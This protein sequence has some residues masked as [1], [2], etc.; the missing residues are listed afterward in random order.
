MQERIFDRFY[1]LEQD[2]R[3][4]VEGS[5][6]GLSL[7]RELTE[8]HGGR[9]SVRSSVSGGSEFQVALPLGFGHFQK[10]EFATHQD[11]A[12]STVKPTAMS[13]ANTT[14]TQNNTADSNKPTLLLV[15]DVADMRDYIASHFYN[16]FNV[17]TA[18]DGQQAW[19]MLQEN[20]FDIVVTDLMM[21]LMD[22]MELLANIRADQRLAST[23]VLVLSAR[24]TTEDR[25]FALAKQADDY[26]AKPFDSDELILR[27]RN[28]RQRLSSPNL[29]IGATPGEPEAPM[30]SADEQWLEKAHQAVLDNL[31]DSAFDTKQ[32]AIEMNV[33]KPTLHRHMEKAGQTT[34][35][36]FIRDIRLQKAQELIT[37][38]AYR[39]IAEVAYAVGFAS[40][41]YFSRLY[42]QRFG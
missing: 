4:G 33:S 19:L 2:D 6:I 9:V 24:S 12:F 26:L 41:G 25:N 29:Q 37:A 36:A 34:P 42:K 1:R 13:I 11:E 8:L 40:P 38:N 22:G 31:A 39:T 3:S 14:S 23:P 5:G 17:R 20:H 15:E 32:L 10:E 28:L 18:S 30:N 7:V 16:E 35:A 27:V 21:P